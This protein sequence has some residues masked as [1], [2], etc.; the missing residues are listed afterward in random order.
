MIHSTHMSS[1]RS[2][3]TRS[4]TTARGRLSRSLAATGAS[5]DRAGCRCAGG[6]PLGFPSQKRLR[7]WV[8]APPPDGEVS[9][10][11]VA[12]A[13]A[14]IADPEGHS[15]PQLE[16]SPPPQIMVTFQMRTLHA[17]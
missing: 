14:S 8:K 10:P 9:S 2:R 7:V 6:Q 4:S 16:A 1:G 12:E 17:K 3:A 5:D 13:A 11:P 15:P